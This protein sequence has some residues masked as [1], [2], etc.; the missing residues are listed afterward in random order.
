M[1]AGVSWTDPATGL[2]V[3][4]KVRGL[5]AHEDGDYGEWGASGAVRI[6]PGADGRG[7]SLTLA[8]AWGADAGGA[9]RLWSLRDARELA[10]EDEPES[11]SRLEAELGYGFSVLD[12]RAV[13]TPWVGMTRSETGG[14]LRLGQR[15]KRWAPRSGA[16]RARSA[17]GSGTYGAGW[18]YR[19]GDALELGLEALRREAA[20]DDAPEHEVMLRARVRW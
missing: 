7:L 10:P 11:G 15:L 17:T 14:T 3:E 2:S 6:E 18:G 4:A 5:V 9:E 8:P 16:S 20:N 1:G 13:A 12:G 19:L